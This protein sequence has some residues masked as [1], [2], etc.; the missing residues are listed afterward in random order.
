MKIL[1]ALILLFSVPAFGQWTVG[2][3][4]FT[5]SS[6][7]G[8]AVTM[9]QAS[10]QTTACPGGAGVT[11]CTGNVFASNTT[12]GNTIAIGVCWVGIG[13]GAT[14]NHLTS[15]S[16]QGG[17]VTI[18]TGS[19]VNY[20]ATTHQPNVGCEWATVTGITGGSTTAVT[21]NFA[22]ADQRVN[23]YAFETTPIG[24]AQ[25]SSGSGAVPTN[26]PSA[27]SI[28]PASNGSLLLDA[29]VQDDGSGCVCGY[30]AGAGYT[31][32]A[33]SGGGNTDTVSQYMAQATAAANTSP[34]TTDR[35]PAQWVDSFLVLHP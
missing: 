21:V 31:L 19:L 11:S 8:G 23:I 12:A 13:A 29:T 9:V 1:L 30:T 4:S 18:I 24:S 25:S 14:N 2:S 32:E 5:P 16:G 17:T 15:I 3:R 26:Q 27:S 7:G 6:V 35:N 22:T 10:I 28:T 33:I 34:L 20:G